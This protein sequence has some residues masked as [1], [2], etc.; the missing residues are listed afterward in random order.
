MNIDVASAYSA[1]GAAWQDGPG[2]IYDRLA[3]VLVER[4]PTV[5]DGA[6]VLD[7]G[8]GT[9]AATRAARR[10]GASVVALDAAIGMLAADAARRPPAAVGDAI[11]LPFAS[12]TFHAAIAAFS[13]NHVADPAAA[14]REAARV[15]QPG[16]AIVASA[17]AADDHHPVKGAVEAAAAAR[18]WV[19]EAW[20]DALRRDIVPMMATVERCAG[21]AAAAGLIGAA[22]E[23]VSVPFPDLDPGDLVAWRLGMAQLAPFV[24]RLPPSER[25]ALAADA[26]ARLGDEAPNLTRSII[27]L[28]FVDRP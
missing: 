27:V 6:F 11:A 1:S 9:G 21:I 12:H 16:G 7:I 18:G 26:L 15:L 4:C 17:Y 13:L 28:T 10:C 5:Q 22:A 19:E 24:D 25:H 8:A 2:R 23:Q 14:L 3:E 20:Y